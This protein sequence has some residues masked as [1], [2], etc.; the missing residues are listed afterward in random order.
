MPPPSPS[1]LACSHGKEGWPSSMYGVSKLAEIAYTRN[2]RT[3]GEG[4]LLLLR[5]L[6]AACRSLGI[7]AQAAADSLPPPSFS[8][9]SLQVLAPQLEQRRVMVNAVCPGELSRLLALP[10]STAPPRCADRPPHSLS[11]LAGWCCTAM[12][13]F[14]GPRSAAQGADTPVWL[15]LLPA[16]EF[17]TGAL[18]CADAADLGRCSHTCCCSHMPPALLSIP[19]R[20]VFFRP[21]GGAVVNRRTAK[22]PCCLRP[23][24]PRACPVAPA[25][26]A[27]LSARLSSQRSQYAIRPGQAQRVHWHRVERAH[28]AGDRRK[29]Q[30]TAS[31]CKESPAESRS[32]TAPSSLSPTRAPCSRPR[33]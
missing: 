2:V 4:A 19:V 7:G 29:K 16:S 15:A 33:S 18:R 8:S 14:R 26:P 11:L 12:S 32:G 10:L 20:Q 30:K 22:Q 23:C 13:S 6:Q 31:S 9:P 28:G 25:A 5:C 27:D 24:C 3:R 21:Q 1:Q 17:V